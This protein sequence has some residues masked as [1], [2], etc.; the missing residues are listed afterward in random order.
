MFVMK[1]FI[2]KMLVWIL[3]KNEVCGS[4]CMWVVVV[5]KGRI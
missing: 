1:D 5:K 2:E 3:K 4:F